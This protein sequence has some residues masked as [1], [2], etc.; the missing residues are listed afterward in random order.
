MVPYFTL[1]L[2]LGEWGK[3][4]GYLNLTHIDFYLDVNNRQRQHFTPCCREAKRWLLHYNSNRT[5]RQCSWRTSLSGRLCDCSSVIILRTRRQR[6]SGGSAFSWQANCANNQADLHCYQRLLSTKSTQVKKLT[7]CRRNDSCWSWINR[8]GSLIQ[9]Q[10]SVFCCFPLH[11][12]RKSALA[13][14][15]RSAF[16][17]V[18]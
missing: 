4:G 8:Y 17:Q 7:A 6:R 2:V 5:E 15:L 14:V 18:E 11:L 16:S 9:K 13:D 12:R 1:G 3:E 10:V